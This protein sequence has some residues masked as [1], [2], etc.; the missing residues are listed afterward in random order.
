M[1]EDTDRGDLPRI[2]LKASERQYYPVLLI[3]LN[4]HAAPE[5][6]PGG[7]Y[8]YRGRVEVV[9]TSYALNQ[10]ELALLRR[11]VEHDD[12]REVIDTVVGNAE[13]TLSDIVG[14]IEALLSPRVA[15]V[16]TPD[17]PNPFTALLDFG[18]TFGKRES[19]D[20][21]HAAARRGKP[22]QAD[23]DFEKV[24]RSQA[25][26]EARKRCL[27]FYEHEK[28]RLQMPLLGNT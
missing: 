10:D 11:E 13:G 28:L 7:G 3:E 21:P 17:N 26:L 8:I 4:I 2:L 20:S 25:I 23:S 1:K 5:R 24:I 22:L 27:E 14:K 6:T 18:G 12:F 15:E 9:A 19:V 16:E